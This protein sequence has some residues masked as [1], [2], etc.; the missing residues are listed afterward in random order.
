MPQGAYALPW[1]NANTKPFLVPDS[2][3]GQANC[4]QFDTF[5]G[6]LYDNTLQTHKTTASIHS[7]E[8][9]YEAASGD[10]TTV[11]AAQIR[12]ALA[13]VRAGKVVF[14]PPE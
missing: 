13:S 8:Q 2:V 14:C 11:Q 3:D 1:P 6:D 12:L 5:L 9:T 4:G 10:H 7:Y